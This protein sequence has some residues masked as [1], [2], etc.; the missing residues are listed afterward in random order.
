ML[1]TSADLALL[2][3]PSL[4]PGYYLVGSGN[5]G[6][7]GSLLILA[8]LYT[9]VIGNSLCKSSFLNPFQGASALAIRR[10]PRNYSIIRQTSPTSSTARAVPPSAV[11]ATPQYWLLFSTA[12]LL[13]TGGMALMS[14]ASPM[15]QEVF[16]PSLP[17]LV[18]PT[19]ASAYLM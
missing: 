19:A 9:S 17:H 5:T 2:P 15:M 14:V 11:M 13:A 16:S 3:F 7:A 4:T 6:V 18:T 12:S 1:C 10:S 8:A